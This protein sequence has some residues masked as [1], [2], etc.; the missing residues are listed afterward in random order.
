MIFI[1]YI[2]IIILTCIILYFIFI[3]YKYFRTKNIKN[4]NKKLE[5]SHQNNIFLDALNN[6]PKIISDRIM[7]KEDR[8]INII[9]YL[10][11][12][13]GTK[14]GM[15]IFF[16]SDTCMACK[17]YESYWTMLMNENNPIQKICDLEKKN[18]KEYI[19]T[20]I[21]ELI[22]HV[23]LFIYIDKD[24]ETCFYSHNFDILF[25]KISNLLNSRNEIFDIEKVNK[26]IDD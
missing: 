26:L 4:I 6:T 25:H 16:Y 1:L 14:E 5:N 15:I 9:Q 20:P 10:K 7:P 17:A 23:P 22:T 3:V 13:K 12:Y 19:G 24:G 21:T 18:I 11:K 8:S 2:F